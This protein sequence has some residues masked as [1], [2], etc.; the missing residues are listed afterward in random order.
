MHLHCLLKNSYSYIRLLYRV[1]R[2]ILVFIISGDRLLRVLHQNFD[3][4][5][6]MC[7]L[8][9]LP[10]YYDQNC[11]HSLMDLSAHNEGNAAVRFVRKGDY[12]IKMWNSDL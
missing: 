5:M 3:M 12:Y 10:T 9:N 6:M 8:P 1:A 7:L 4:M 2:Y 11:I